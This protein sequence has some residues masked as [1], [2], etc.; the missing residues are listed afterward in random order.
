MISEKLMP[1][2][3]LPDI[4]PVILLYFIGESSPLPIKV[5]TIKATG[6]EKK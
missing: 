4:I 3:F 2:L 1:F 6:N 5:K